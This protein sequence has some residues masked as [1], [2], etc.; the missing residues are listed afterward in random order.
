MNTRLIMV[1]GTCAVA[2]P[3]A[4]T[5]GFTPGT[6][7]SSGSYHPMPSTRTVEQTKSE[8]AAWQRVPVSADGFRQINGDPGWIYVGT[9][10]SDRTR[11]QVLQELA[12]FRR[13]KVTA[14]GWAFFDGERGWTFVGPRQQ[15]GQGASSRA[16]TG[17][18]VTL[19]QRQ[20]R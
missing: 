2:L 9:G 18:S 6:G 5:S 12:D 16:S 10:R 19:G 11:A 7:E 8:L 20:S 3:A 13:D 15:T 1:L 14:D 4:A 17:D